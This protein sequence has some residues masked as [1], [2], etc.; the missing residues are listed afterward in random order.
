M[1]APIIDLH[2]DDTAARDRLAD[3]LLH[4]R[5]DARLAVWEV[6]ARLDRTSGAVTQMQKSRAWGVALVQRWARAVDQRLTI[7]LDGLAVPEDGDELAAIYA[8]AT[9]RSPQAVDR[10]HLRVVV[11]NLARV[12]RSLGIPQSVIAARLGLGESAIGWAENAP[13]GWRVAAVQRYARALGG[14]AVFELAP[15]EAGR[16]TA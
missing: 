5:T 4:A 7:T 8:A 3:A 2:P 11:N 15:V 16:V 9:P 13:D 10:L 14:V 12:R 6:A 1:S